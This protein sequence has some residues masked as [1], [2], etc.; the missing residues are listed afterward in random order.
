VFFVYRSQTSSNE[1]ATN[2]LNSGLGGPM[3]GAFIRRGLEVFVPDLWVQFLWGD[4][5]IEAEGVVAVGSIQNSQPA[6]WDPSSRLNILQGAFAFEA[7]YHLLNRQLGIYFNAGWASGDADVEGLARE[8]API[9]QPGPSGVD[10]TQSTFY[11]HPAYRI[12]LIFWRTI[13][14]QIGGAYYFRPGLSYDFIRNSFGQL[15]GA[16]AD[17]VYSRASEAVQ[18]WGNSADLGLEID[19]QVYYRSEDGPDLFDGFYVS[20]QYGIFFPFQGLGFLPGTFAPG[21]APTGG[22]NAQT[23]RLVLGV[24]Y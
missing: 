1:G 15:L 18:T 11:M 14:R 8:N 4:L 2:Q 6:N 22:Q 19:A 13:M 10:H 9:Q 17:V 12:D 23:L 24:Q 16:R 5:R 7:E 3:G 20:V 21:V